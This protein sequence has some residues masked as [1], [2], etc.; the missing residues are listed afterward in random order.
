MARSDALGLRGISLR[1]K[2]RV[3]KNSVIQGGAPVV[4]PNNYV[5][6]QETP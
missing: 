2:Y 5:L 4:L 1:A 6:H 3:C